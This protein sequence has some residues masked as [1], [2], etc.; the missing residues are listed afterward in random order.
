MDI[1]YKGI[2]Q[3]I[4]I[5][6]RHTKLDQTLWADRITVKTTIKTNLYALVYGKRARLPSHIVLPT[7]KILQE[8][9]ESFEPLEIRMN[10]LIHLEE[11]KENSYKELQKRHGIVKRWFDGKKAFDTTFK[12][13]ELV[14]KWDEEKEKPRKHKKFDS[15]WSRPYVISKRIGPNAFEITRLDGHI[16]PITVNGQHLKSYDPF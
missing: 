4:T 2:T 14:L 3:K 5:S 10:E 15:L 8:Y 7:M 9:G 13:G 12:E 11:K 16:L 1:G 6:R